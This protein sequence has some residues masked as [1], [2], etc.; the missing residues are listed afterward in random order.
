MRK[1]SLDLQRFA[2]RVF[3]EPAG[4]DLPERLE[5]L[6]A[7]LEALR[8]RLRP[9]AEAFEVRMEAFA[10]GA[11][12]PVRLPLRGDLE[13]E[14]PGLLLDPRFW[15]HVHASRRAAL[16]GEK[17]A[18]RAFAAALEA[19]EI[20]KRRKRRAK[21]EVEERRQRVAEEQAV[22][23]AASPGLAAAAAGFGIEAWGTGGPLEKLAVA[24][25][26]KKRGRIPI[27]ARSLF[28]SARPELA[29]LRR[30]ESEKARTRDPKRREEL[31]RESAAL[32]EKLRRF[33]L[34]LEYRRDEAARAE[35]TLKKSRRVK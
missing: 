25:A 16:Y 2:E 21:R 10:R 35:R 15:I 24:I 5:R 22:A 28:Q 6:T 4:P 11:G 33:A 8:E 32:R 9:D 3:G 12:K 27:R 7:A 17:H 1:P 23:F 19:L 13:D 34:T 14:A 18:E 31:Q 20:G 26:R 30:L 29:R